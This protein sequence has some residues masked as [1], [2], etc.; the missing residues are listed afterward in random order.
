MQNLRSESTIPHVEGH[1]FTVDEDTLDLLMMNGKS[2][3]KYIGE[4]LVDFD[5]AD[6]Y[7]YDFTSNDMIKFIN[8]ECIAFDSGIAS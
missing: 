7:S 3:K 2:K 4:C 1:G 5:S 6:L 8:E